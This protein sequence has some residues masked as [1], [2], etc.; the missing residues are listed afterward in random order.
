[1][2]VWTSKQL[3]IG[4]LPTSTGSWDVFR[5]VKLGEHF[6]IKLTVTKHQGQSVFGDLLLID[7]D[8]KVISQINAAEVTCSPSLSELFKASA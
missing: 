6:F 8:N 3:G 1:L 7:Q 5:E 2:L 4:S